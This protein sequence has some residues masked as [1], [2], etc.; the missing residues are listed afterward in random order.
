MT[1]AF[2]CWAEAEKNRGRGLEMFV[3]CTRVHAAVWA[4]AGSGVQS[5]CLLIEKSISRSAHAGGHYSALKIQDILIS[6][7]A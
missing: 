7:T 4:G 1:P 5:E 2:G 6:A 3:S